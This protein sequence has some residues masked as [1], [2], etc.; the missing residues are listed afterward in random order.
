MMAKGANY[1]EAKRLSAL[2][3]NKGQTQTQTQAQKGNDNKKDDNDN[4]NDNNG[5]DDDEDEE[6]LRK[7][8]KMRLEE[9][10]NEKYGSVI[11]IQRNEWNHQVND[12]SRDG[13][14]VVI[15]LTA[16]KSSPSGQISDNENDS[17]THKDICTYIE[18]NTIPR[19]ATK[20]PA[21]KFVK[22]PSKSAIE[23]FPDD[24]LPT[25]F[26]YRYGKLQ[27]QLVGLEEFGIGKARARMCSNSR[28]SRE[29]ASRLGTMGV[30]DKKLDMEDSDD[31]YNEYDANANRS[32]RS[33]SSST[34][35]KKQ[36]NRS[37]FDGK[38]AQLQTG[39]YSCGDEESD[40]DDVD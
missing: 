13:T 3:K 40:Y 26:C 31:E 10:R 30:L 29:I 8:R 24:N 20:Y 32:I 25:L 4:S 11:P 1:E 35:I 36:Y 39:M 33:T 22:I 16:Q 15:Y 2:K 28:I 38:V 37:H 6:F 18:D 9:L 5:G 17:H 21:V 34:G 12:A 19:L 23:N 14:W 7:Y 27:C